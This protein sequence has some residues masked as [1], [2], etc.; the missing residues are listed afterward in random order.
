[1]TGMGT[2]AVATT[3]VAAGQLLSVLASPLPLLLITTVVVLVWL[4]IAILLLTPMWS[5]C[6]ERNARAQAMLD[7]VLAAIPG[8]RSTPASSTPPAG[9]P[10]TRARQI[11]SR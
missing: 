7:R 11:E 1:V 8:S 5:S 10:P 3:A 6:P 4:P 2:A 9:G